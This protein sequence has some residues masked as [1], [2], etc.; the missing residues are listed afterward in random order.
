M[1]TLLRHGAVYAPEPLGVR[2]VLLVGGQVAR[3]GLVDEAAVRALGL[4]YEVID[5]AGGLVIPG[6]VDPHEHFIGAGGEKGFRT[7]M[8]EVSF[9]QLARAGVTTA[10]GCLGTDGVTRSL[11]ALVGKARQLTEEGITALVYTGGFHIPPRTLTGTIEGDL[12]LIDLVVGVGELA[13]SDVR[14]SQPHLD[15]LARVVASATVGGRISGKAGVTHFH[16]GPGRGRL[17]L[18]HALLDTHEV[19]PSC[20]YITHANRTPELMDDAIALA[21]RGAY[22]DLD[23]VDPPLGPWVRQYRERGGPPA[24][25]T[26]SSDAHTPGAHPGRLREELAALVRD[27]HL[28]LE[29]VLPYFTANP[30]SALRLGR[31]GRLAPGM[32]AD[33][34]VLDERTLEVAHVFARGRALVREGRLVSREG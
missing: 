23:T 24:R 9:E 20:L 7:R 31:K 28:P 1:M 21:H 18:L 15:E 14:S 10:V 27:E 33:V 13:I 34:V 8:P 6:F 25:L 32:D 16:A 17:S 30:A 5:V 4:P 11:E 19:D 22:V 12:V 2:S 3:I 26:M 29:E